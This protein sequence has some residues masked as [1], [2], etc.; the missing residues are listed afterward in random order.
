[1]SVL[2]EMRALLG[3]STVPGKT[4][5]DKKSALAAGKAW[6]ESRFKSLQKDRHKSS[7]NFQLDDALDALHNVSDGKRDDLAHA[8]CAA[9]S[10]RL[11]ELVASEE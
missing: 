8:M 6:A 10:K 9:A 5:T 11:K 7:G 2:A 4:V 1:M 3:E